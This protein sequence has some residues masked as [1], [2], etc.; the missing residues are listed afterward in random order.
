M[1]V[2]YDVLNAGLPPRDVELY[3]IAACLALEV[4]GTTHRI[5]LT[6]EQWKLLAKSAADAASDGLDRRK[7]HR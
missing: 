4:D 2:S 5:Y 6:P 3:R 1:K 7:A